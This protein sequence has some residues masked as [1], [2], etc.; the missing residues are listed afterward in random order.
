RS[1]TAPLHE[2]IVVDNGSTDASRDVVERLQREPQPWRVHLIECLRPGAAAAM[3]DGIA[4]ATGDVIVRLDGHSRPNADYVR[5]SL[6]HFSEPDTGVVGGVWHVTAGGAGATAR[7]IAAALT[8]RFATGGAA[9]RHPD[10]QRQPQ[11]VDTVPFGC[12]RKALWSDLGGYDESLTI[13]EDYVFNLM[14]RQSGLKVILDPGI[15]ATYVARDTFGRLAR[16]YFG[17]GWVKAAM[18]VR[19]PSSLRFRQLLPVLWCAWLAGAGMLS[20][21]A[22]GLR[23]PYLIAGAGYLAVLLAASAEVAYRTSTWS[24]LPRHLLALAVIQLSWGTGALL[25]WATWFA[26]RSA[27]GANDGGTAPRLPRVLCVTGAYAPEFSSGGL[28]VRAVAAE[29]RGRADLRVLTTAVD[30]RLP[31]EERVDGVRV[32]RV[33][34]AI[35]SPVSRLLA[36]VRLTRALFRIIPEVDVIHVQ[37]YSSKNIP[38]RLLSR[39][40]RRP[41]VMHLQTARHDEPETIRAH[42]ALAWWAFRSADYVVSVSPALTR[43]YLDAGLPLDRIR[44]IPNSVDPRRFAPASPEERRSLRARLN[45]PAEGALMLFVGV[46]SPDKRPDVLLKAWLKLQHAPETACALVYVGATNPQLFELGDRLDER[47]RASVAD[48][49]LGARVRFVEPTPRVED[50]FRAADIFAMPSAREGLPI[51]LIEAMACGLPCVASRLPGAT[52]AVITSGVD[53][54]LVPPDDVSSLTQHLRALLR[55]PHLAAQAGRMARQTVE[56]RFTVDRVAE[57]WLTMYRQ[58]LLA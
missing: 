38:V 20:V 31:R 30:H 11:Q 18:L 32:S 3:N 37:G 29:L 5:L 24:L 53:G 54:W 55:D 46:I 12:F 6:A 33:P 48:A 58:V 21:W 28:Q 25:R 42:G 15:Q 10:A 44:E 56:R 34:I 16:Q 36:G 35:A 1:Q 9:Y 17:Y 50:Y 40:W 49:G 13:N 4:A 22:E 19:F 7:S 23:A 39:L 26:R 43:S 45:L 14:A 57:Q 27:A 47:L 8:S 52:D 2:V 41:V 51:S